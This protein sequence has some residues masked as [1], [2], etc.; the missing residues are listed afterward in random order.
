KLFHCR[1]PLGLKL[2]I[3]LFIPDFPMPTD[4]CRSI[5]KPLVERGDA[6]YNLSR[7][8]LL[9][10]GLSTGKLEYLK[11]G[12]QDRLHQPS[13]QE[14]FPAMGIIF[15]AALSA[16]AS[17]VFLSGSGSTILAMCQDN[18]EIIGKAMLRAG[19]QQGLKAKVVFT[20]PTSKGV[21]LVNHKNAETPIGSL[22]VNRTQ[23]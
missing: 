20:T 7:V 8:A 15:R 5:L 23:N 17:A 6:V 21:H 18:G 9:A 1:I 22:P 11:F 10:T 12:T 16:G 3:I 14:L 19:K 2:N 13:R 4:R